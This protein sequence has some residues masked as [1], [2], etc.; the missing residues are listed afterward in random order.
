MIY[1][2]TFQLPETT[3]SYFFTSTKSAICADE[4]MESQPLLSNLRRKLSVPR[5]K[6]RHPRPP[7]RDTRPAYRQNAPP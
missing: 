3:G 5:R 4:I 6:N 7:W 1:F 2:T